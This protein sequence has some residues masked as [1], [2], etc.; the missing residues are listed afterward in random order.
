MRFL[1]FEFAVDLKHVHFFLCAWL[2]GAGLAGPAWASA[3]FGGEAG[4]FIGTWDKG[5]SGGSPGSE[6]SL[7]ESPGTAQSNRQQRPSVQRAPS[8]ATPDS[9]AAHC[10]SPRRMFQPRHVAV[11]IQKLQ[12]LIASALLSH[13]DC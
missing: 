3:A 1:V 4:F 2:F 9:G 11:T 10:S 12:H 6:W 13:G 8:T 5:S 7:S